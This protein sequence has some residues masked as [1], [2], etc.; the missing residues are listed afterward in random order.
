MSMGSWL[1]RYVIT[2]L[3]KRERGEGLRGLR[4]TSIKG[5]K[6]IV[7]SKF[8]EAQNVGYKQVIETL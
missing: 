4:L 3:K 8:F 5:H 7:I 2:S 6:R 1:L